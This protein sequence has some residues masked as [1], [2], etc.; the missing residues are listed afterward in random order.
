MTIAMNM[1]NYKIENNDLLQTL[2]GDEVLCSGW[3][4]EIGLLP[5]QSA[6]SEIGK[7]RPMPADLA[8][9]DTEV[10]LKKMYTYQK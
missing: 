7:S 5:Q 4:P 6:L 10:F 1:N 2:Y 3:I 8:L 9:V